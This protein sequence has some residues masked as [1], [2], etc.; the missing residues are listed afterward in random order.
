MTS[1]CLKSGGLGWSL[2]FAIAVVNLQ[3]RFD[4]AFM[5]VGLVAGDGSDWLLL[6][7]SLLS[8][9]YLPA[10]DGH[11]KGQWQAKH[12]EREEDSANSYRI[13]IYS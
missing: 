7:S 5:V 1:L 8:V 11:I 3:N 6:L 9:R 13:E 4:L 12:V 10:A 2:F